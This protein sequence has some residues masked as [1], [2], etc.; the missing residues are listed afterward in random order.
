MSSQRQAGRK[1]WHA[2]IILGL[3]VLA[4]AAAAIAGWRYARESPPHQGPI[5]VFA[6][7]S[8][9]GD[10]I[11]AGP[12][13]GSDT[14]ALDALAADGVVFSRAYT[15]STAILPAFTS[16]STGQLPFEHGVRDDGGFT[17]PDSARTMAELLRNRG[18]VTG[19]A[20]STFL[21]RRATGLGQ[22]FGF[23]DVDLPEPSTPEAVSIERDG[24]QTYEAAEEWIRAQSNQRYFLVLDLD[25]ES[26]EPVVAR[27]VNELKAR[28]LY[29]EATL[30][31][32]ADRGER[33]NGAGLD[34]STLH[35]PLIVKQP[36]AEAAGRQISTPV[37]H[38]D[39]L[40]TLLDFVRA[41]IPGNLRGRSLR[42]LLDDADGTLPEQL[43]YSESLEAAMRFGGYPVYALTDGAARL[44]RGATDELTAIAGFSSSPPPISTLVAALDR[45]LKDQV[46]PGPSAIAPA[47]ER[48]YAAAGYLAGLRQWSA[49]S[50]PLESGDQRALV[51]AHRAGVRRLALG[52]V[53][54]AI[55]ALRAIVRTHPALPA[56]QFQ[57]GTQ[58]LHAGRL[59]EALTALRAADDL[60]PEDAQIATA[61]AVT[62]L[63]AGQMAEAGA[64]AEMAVARA[65][66]ADVTAKVDA[67]VV[68]LEVALAAKNAEAAAMHVA[69]IERVDST[70]PLGDYVEGRVAFDEGRFDDAVAALQNAARA[71]Q[72]RSS[73]VPDLQLV[74]GDALVQLD[75]NTE[76]EAAYRQ[77]LQT[78]PA[79][80][81][82]YAS[83]ATMYHASDRDE[84]MSQTL[85]ALIEAIPTAEGYAAAVR[86]WTAAGNRARAN[87]LR[88]EARRRFRGDPTLASLR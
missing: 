3:F 30:I 53:P 9:R 66:S 10:A 8:L 77:E 35:V 55:A 81:R 46:L 69:E 43:I 58:L 38:I 85:D 60:R 29:D 28:N 68:A 36:F 33:G 63:R 76:A 11:G 25:R 41:P 64:Y 83:L 39:L 50:P 73:V 47:E 88:T 67:R 12:R 54:A 70:L 24:L 51:E 80:V 52:D 17:L 18:F 22:G 45:L 48:Q 6:I 2:T 84:A 42:P 82:A 65:S 14:P 57:L 56:V 31:V 23:Y 34:E 20:A 21:L 44:V 75:R 7:E 32:T 4:V 79:S 1:R 37:Q 72:S 62:A 27:L 87:E 78:F 26:A 15:H 71:L 74:L 13:P 59:T 16:L 5:I 40:P 86:V 19:G 61:L 49:L